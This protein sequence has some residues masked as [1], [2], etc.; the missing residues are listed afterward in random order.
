MPCRNETEQLIL[1]H[2]IALFG[3]R[4]KYAVSIAD[5]AA[6]AGVNKSLIFY[7]FGSKDG[8]YRAAFLSL[9]EELAE[10]VEERV[11]KLEPGMNMIVQFSR[12]QIGF[13][14]TH[15]ALVRFMVRELLLDEI[16]GSVLLMEI[17]KKLTPFRDLIRKSFQAAMERG[18][19]RPVD[20]A[21]TMVNILSLN[22]FFFLGKPIVKL[23]FD[24]IDF[25]R[26]ERERED[27][28]ID[29]LLH[30]LERQGGPER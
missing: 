5:I 13:L 12:E 14:K 29:L 9:V 30:G 18:E 10:T 19:I 7:Y 26:F 6:S 21:Q 11:G 23:V 3:N 8:L 27:H 28:V 24:N 16:E 4:G 22:V 15:P 20:P 1:D 17:S 25:E 2:A